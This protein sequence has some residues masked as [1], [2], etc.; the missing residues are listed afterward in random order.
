MQQEPEQ[1]N[2]T[3][4]LPSNPDTN[5][6]M[7]VDEQNPSFPPPTSASSSASAP[8]P[9]SSSF[10]ASS[11][12]SLPPSSS[13]PPSSQSNLPMPASMYPG[14]MPPSHGPQENMMQVSG[15]MS[16]RQQPRTGTQPLPTPRLPKPW[17]AATE[18]IMQARESIK[19]FI[20]ELLISRRQNATPDWTEKLPTMA[21]RLEDS[22]Y[23]QAP[24]FEEYSDRSTLKYRL[25]A[26]AMQMNGN[27][28]RQMQQQQQQQLQQQQLQH[29]QHQ[30]QQ[31]QYYQQNPHLQPQMVQ[32]Q[33]HAEGASDANNMNNN[34]LQSGYAAD[35]NRGNGAANGMNGVAGDGNGGVMPPRSAVAPA[36]HTD[37]HR[38]QVLKQQQQRLLLLRHA[39]KCPHERCQ[40]TPHCGNMKLLWK[41]I[42]SCKD[43]ECKTPH[44]VSSRYVL[45]HYSKC[46]DRNCPVCGPVREAIRRNYD[47]NQIVMKMAQQ[48]RGF[49]PGMRQQDM[50]YNKRPKFEQ[51]PHHQPRP[52]KLLDP[53]SC[54]M[55][56]FTPE[57]IKSHFTTIHEG[58][59]SAHLKIR[60]VCQPALEDLYK[61]P[62]VQSIFGYPVDPIQ[63]NIPDYFDII[64]N[65]MDLGTVKKKMETG[66]YR[67]LQSFQNDVYLVFDNAMLYNPK[68]TPVND[69]AKQLKKLFDQRFKASQLRYEHK[70]HEARQQHDACLFCGESLLKFE[71][72]VYYC[73]GKCGGQR[74]RRNAFFYTGGNNAYH[75]CSP[76]F[77]ELKDDQPIRMIDCTL[78]KSEI[79]KT[80]KK[81]TDEGLEESWVQCDQCDRWAH[82]VCALFNNR[83]NISADIEYLCPHCLQQRRL[84]KTDAQIMMPS[85]KKTQ[86]TDLPHCNLTLFIE[87]RI[88]ER[89]ERAYA[90]TAA[91][92]GIPV[93]QVE[94]CPQLCLR[95]VSSY[96]KS[97]YTREGMIQRYAH[98]N[99]PSEFPSRVKCLVLFQCID[100][101]M[102]IL[103]GM[104][105][106]EYGHKC[107]QPNQ[108]RVYISYLDSVHYFRPRQYRTMVYHEILVSYLEWMKKRGFHTCH[109]WACPPLKG[110]DYIMH[111]HPS[112]QKTPKD[113]KLR[114]WY[115][116][117]L[118]ICQE[119]GIVVEVSDLYTEFLANPD[120][121][122]SQLPYF[123]GDYL[124]QEAEVIIKNLKNAPALPPAPVAVPVPVPV[125]AAAPAEETEGGGNGTGDAATGAAGEGDGHDDTDKLGNK[126]KR[127]NKRK[128]PVVNPAKRQIRSQGPPQ[129]WP[130]NGPE[131]DPVVVKL[132]SIIEPMK[133]AFFVAR[134][135]PKE[136]AE[137]WARQRE[138]ELAVE[139]A[140]KA[141]E[142]DERRE[143]ALQDEALSGNVY[144]PSVTDGTVVKEPSRSQTPNEAADEEEDDF[145]AAAGNVTAEGDSSI[146]GEGPVDSETDDKSTS[147]GRSKSTKGRSNKISKSASDA[148]KAEENDETE[149]GELS[150]RGSRRS[151]TVNTKEKEKEAD[152]EPSPAS[153]S[154]KPKGRTRGRTPTS[155][156]TV[157]ESKD[158]SSPPSP[159]S[160]STQNGGTAMEVDDDTAQ[161]SSSPP[162]SVVNQGEASKAS[163][164]SATSNMLEATQ[165]ASSE[166]KTEGS[167]GIKVEGKEGAGATEGM[168]VATDS[169]GT[170]SNSTVAGTANAAMAEAKDERAEGVSGDSSSNN[171]NPSGDKSSASATAPSSSSSSSSGA[172]AES[173]EGNEVATT[174]AARAPTPI[175]KAHVATPEELL[176]MLK[177]D[178]EDVDDTQASEHFDSRQSFLNLC[179]GNHYQFDQLRRSKHT[180]MMVLYHLHN[181]DAP[182]FVPNC[183]LCHKDILNNVGLHCP[184]CDLHFCEEC[185]R[186]KG[187]PRIHAHGLRRMADS[188]G[189]P[190]KLTEEQRR[191]RQRNM[192]IHLQLLQHAST[193]V[194]AECP[195]KN[196]S[197]MRELLKHE[198]TCT[199]KVQRGCQ[200]CKRVHSIIQLHARQCRTE[201]CRV[202]NCAAIREHL[203]QMEM[204]Q[205]LMDD[206]RRAMMNEMYQQT[207]NSSAAQEEIDK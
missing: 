83:R 42:M 129:P 117:Q 186:M 6:A 5:N 201:N 104:Y 132:A 79:A 58:M 98:K 28:T 80:K 162:S 48:P 161:A 72:P 176:A 101:Q 18:E 78:I 77:G 22:L 181:P 61:Q 52:H 112:D 8:A 90:E 86:A 95:Q 134:L 45:S 198:A 35:A 17:H 120:I 70:L 179:Q 1:A 89:L 87:K 121:D 182:K 174:A 82:I 118:A 19:N 136:K 202:P 29:Q 23:Y 64:K 183:N 125:P 20:A 193:C 105:V 43:Q 25:Q 153:S 59:K 172:V 67:D 141:S 103:F 170:M 124:V 205:Q 97:Q 15:D 199:L 130:S 34:T 192:L 51:Y 148:S 158:S 2:S 74:I 111:I 207:A 133:E 144:V 37:E 7:Q 131:R 200:I 10:S 154:P 145:A 195:N 92:L 135:H 31:Q 40:V 108:R 113:D 119:R 142:S 9:S 75:W 143:K 114:K 177:D 11:D 196:C 54:A 159:L 47:R 94:K 69:L 84:T 81:H 206:R 147:S 128:G 123:E 71:P 62:S 38:R 157:E 3:S 39:S 50:Q 46:R 169:A 137:E 85:T 116:D 21:S 173:K 122:A 156:A 56:T 106:Y 110:D 44:C 30:Q 194:N 16:Q 27:K 191:E 175:E 185:W 100:G 189:A 168:Q 187:G 178:T 167:N 146:V 33:P 76:C 99:Y 180:S 60:E 96:D 155:K 13:Y 126:S 190:A 26:L 150:R 188:G 14:G 36:A 127:K 109:I 73:N 55:Y 65:P 32:Q 102:V 12:P 164:T 184:A 151:L 171:L 204:R 115:V 203:K 140:A 88:E 138:A 63:L 53:V 107:P 197:K 160:S 91:K 41:H 68:G 163:T 93:D 57:Q 165:N 149:G 49:V 66:G 166:A 24:T 139:A 152:D 4:N